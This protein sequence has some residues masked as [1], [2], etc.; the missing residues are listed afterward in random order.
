[1]IYTPESG[2]GHSPVF[3]I[4]AGCVFDFVFDFVLEIYGTNFGFI[5]LLRFKPGTER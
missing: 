5:S 4:S 3:F 1:L 2:F